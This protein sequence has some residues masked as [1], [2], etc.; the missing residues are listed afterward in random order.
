[1]FTFNGR[2]IG[3]GDN[4][5]GNAAISTSGQY[6]IPIQTEASTATIKIQNSTELPMIITGVD[7]TGYYNEVAAQE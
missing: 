4:L 5:T 3:S 1:M 7:F 2:V 6:S